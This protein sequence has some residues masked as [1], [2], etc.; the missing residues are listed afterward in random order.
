M[1]FKNC[2]EAKKAYTEGLKI[3]LD[4]GREG[5]FKTNKKIMEGQVNPAFEYLKINNDLKIL[6]PYLEQEEDINLKQAVAVALLPHYEEI[7]VHVLEDISSRDLPNSFTA[8]MVLKQ[9]RK[10]IH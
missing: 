5:D 10:G 8:S 6:I 4:A 7:S 3:A 2:D 9:W 1:D